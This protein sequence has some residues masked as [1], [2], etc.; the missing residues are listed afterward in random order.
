MRRRGLIYL[1]WAHLR[2]SRRPIELFVKLINMKKDGRRE[3]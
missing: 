1:H 3:K 2:D